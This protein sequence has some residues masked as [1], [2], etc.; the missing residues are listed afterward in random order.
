MNVY[1]VEK[2]QPLI[3]KSNGLLDL[4]TTEKINPYIVTMSDFIKIKKENYIKY[5][6]NQT[7]IPNQVFYNVGQS[8]WD[9]A[10]ANRKKKILNLSLFIIEN[11]FI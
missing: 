10:Q 6:N 8:L 11:Y 7:G 3:I 2:K 5:T 4:I 9:R 1:I